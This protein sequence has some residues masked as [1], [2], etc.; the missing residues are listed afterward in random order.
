MHQVEGTKGYA[1]ATERFIEATA[2]INFKELHQ[3]FIG[4]IPTKPGRVL[5]V[6]AGIGRDAAVFAGMGHAVVAV[7]PTA[8]FRVAARRLYDSPNIAW[9]DDALPMLAGLGRQADQFDFVLA[10]AVWHHLDH[11]EQEDAMQRIFEL[12]CPEG[13][14]AL[15]LRH[16]PSGVGT[17]VFPT[18]GQQTV[19]RAEACGFSTLL[20][21]PNQPSLLKGKE[22]VR[23]TRLVFVKS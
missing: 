9:V 7:E 16:G 23:W 17:H 10:S 8:D 1:E 13:V 3:D 11:V 14:F 18:H 19:D 20:C 21:R 15:S 12:V 6:G 4:F 2:A 5:D 22:E